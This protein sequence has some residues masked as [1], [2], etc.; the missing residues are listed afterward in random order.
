MSS[1]P[2]NL[3]L[4]DRSSIQEDS[5]SL[6]LFRAAFRVRRPPFVPLLLGLR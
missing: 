5:D 2:A 1:V 6:D 3:G 4:F